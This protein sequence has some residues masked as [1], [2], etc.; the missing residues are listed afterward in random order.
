LI[1]SPGKIIWSRYPVNKRRRQPYF[2]LIL[3]ILIFVCI[4]IKYNFAEAKIIKNL[5][6]KIY[7]H[8][9]GDFKTKLYIWY[10]NLFMSINMTTERIDS[11]KLF[12]KM[13]KKIF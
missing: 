13:T 1:G 4:G 11:C 9:N 7:I 10:L 6:L 8:Y 2:V 12:N 5:N 3:G